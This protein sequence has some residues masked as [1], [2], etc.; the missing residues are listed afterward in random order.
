M[1]LTGWTEAMAAEK[2]GNPPV[3]NGA[4]TSSAS[5]ATVAEDDDDDLQIIPSVVSGKKRKLP[6]ISDE[7]NTVGKDPKIKRKAAEEVD[8]N[9]DIV[10]LDDDNSGN[11][12]KKME[13]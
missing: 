12:K 1:I 13:P 7:V 5:Q 8:G 9:N 4:S 10:M 6:D 3:D 2:N 11:S